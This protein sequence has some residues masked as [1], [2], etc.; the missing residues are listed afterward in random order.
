[1]QPINSLSSRRNKV[2]LALLAGLLYG[3]SFSYAGPFLS[4][5]ALCALLYV[6]L[7]ADTAR[8]AFVFS[9]LFWVPGFAFGLRWLYDSIVHYGGV[10]PVFGVAGLLCFAAYL[11]CFASAASALAARWTPRG[12]AARLLAL[13]SLIGLAEWVRASAGAFGWLSPGYAL[14]DT[15]VAHWAAVGGIGLVN[16]VWLSTAALI[17]RLCCLPGRKRWAAMWLALILASSWGVQ[18]LRWSTPATRSQW[19][20]VQPDLPVTTHPTAAENDVR[21]AKMLRYAEQRW[22]AKAET[23]RALLLPEG[24]V[25]IPYSHLLSGAR[26]GLEALVREASAPVLFTALRL[27]GGRVYNSAFWFDGRVDEVVDKR[28]LVPFGEYVPGLLRWLPELFGVAIGDMTPG[29]ERAPSPYFVGDT[30]VAVLI[31]YENLFGDL[32]PSFWQSGRAPEL[33][34]VTSNL[35]WFGASV[36]KQHLD[37]T[38]LR[39]IESARPFLS[40]NNNGGSALVAPD[41]ALLARLSMGQASAFWEVTGATGRSTPFLRFGEA[42][43]LLLFAASVAAALALAR[44]A[45]RQTPRAEGL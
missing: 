44:R 6:A 17:V 15:P 7:Q 3:A 25:S 23:G 13:V 11:S 12:G 4:L 35:A 37:M 24:V 38:R 9:F 36:V 27:D 34:V 14:L 31:C 45:R 28:R 29:D 42:P 8:S 5:I 1:M 43:A 32:L 41:G 30:P 20:V 18:A 21:I 10:S 22:P 33:F 16:A 26:S 40:V 19:H 2:A 39:A